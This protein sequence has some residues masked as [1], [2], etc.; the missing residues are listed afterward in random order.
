VKRAILAAL[1]L[2]GTAT[3]AFALAPADT[4]RMRQANYKQ[5]AAALKGVNDQLRSD[6]PSLP[7]LR[8]NAGLI[9]RHALQVLNWFPRGTGAEAGIRTRA[10]AEIWSDPQGFRRAGARLL[11][12]ARGL[13]AAAGRG[14]VAAVRTAFGE[15]RGACGGC[16][17]AFR[18][19]E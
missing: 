12:A 4:I 16:H 2:A 13:D 17:D 7:E 1:A 5:M 14:D 10:K 18:A 6:A 8:R 11:V 9:S 3:A 15:V 19:P